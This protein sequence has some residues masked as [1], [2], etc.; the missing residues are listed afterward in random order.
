VADRADKRYLR[1]VA[2]QTDAGLVARAGLYEHQRPRVDLVGE[3]MALLGDVDGR[4]VVDVG[5]GNGQ[6]IPALRAGG[7]RVVGIDLSAGM[8]GA[9]TD[10]PPV[11]VGDAE[12]LPLHDG[13][14]DVIVQA[15]MLYH[16]PDPNRA[17]AEAARVLGTAG[18]LLVATNGPGHLQ[19]LEDVWRAVLAGRQA[20]AGGADVALTNSRFG[21]VQATAVLERH[22]KKVTTHMRRSVVVVDD[23]SPLLR[24]ARSTVGAQNAGPTPLAELERRLAERLRTDGELRVTT[25]VAL[26]LAAR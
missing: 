4:V 23:P 17:V 1:D 13:C 6:Y 9:I 21:S 20:G 7:A 3:V 11:I 15:H 19:E 16:V 18:R 26:I 14:A 25:E 10:P 8:L 12:S 2:Y 24:H 5:C 22:F